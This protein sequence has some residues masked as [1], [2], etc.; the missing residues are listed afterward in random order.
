MMQLTLD[1]LAEK[2]KDI[3]FAMLSTHAD[4]GQIGA[5]PMSNNQ[6][7]AYGGDSFYFTTEDTLMV[8]D[9]E[10]DP[11]VGLSFQGRT[12]LLKQNPLFIAVEGRA[13]LIRDRDAFRAHW[14]SQLQDW[15]EEGPDTPGLV[16][17]KVHA[18]RAHIW[19]GEN[20]A[21]LELG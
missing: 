9:I 13:D 6:D 5:R 16:M 19:D 11:R 7:V 12:G 3:D 4:G 20:E 17:I 18:Q 1:S 21:E 2:M 10:R 8:K 14:N 15:F